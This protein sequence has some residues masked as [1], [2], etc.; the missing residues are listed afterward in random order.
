MLLTAGLQDL[1]VG[2]LSQAR[3]LRLQ[4]ENRRDWKESHFQEGSRRF[5]TRHA[6][7]E[8][9][10]VRVSDDLREA[11]SRRVRSEARSVVI[12]P[13]DMNFLE[14]W[15]VIRVLERDAAA[16]LIEALLK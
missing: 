9:L 8:R 6:Q 14:K 15:K 4:R 12:V 5:L 2:R 16:A 11:Q 1:P 13:Q 3:V 7:V 10:R